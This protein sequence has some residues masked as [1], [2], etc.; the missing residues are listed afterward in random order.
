M[1]RDE[2]QKFKERL[3]RMFGYDIEIMLLNYG[4]KF[5]K[6]DTSEEVRIDK[7]NDIYKLKYGKD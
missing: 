2:V 3:F 7:L 1:T 5:V 4:F 6:D